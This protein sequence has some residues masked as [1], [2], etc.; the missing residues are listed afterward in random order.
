[1]P[2]VSAGSFEVPSQLRKLIGVI[3]G[4]A[5]RKGEALLCDLLQRST[6]T[7]EEAVE[8]DAWGAGI[9]GH[10]VHFLVPP[11]VFMRID[12]DELEGLANAV[13]E[14]LNKL[15][16]V[17]NEY[18]SEVT[19]EV[20]E[21]PITGPVRPVPTRE[22][23]S[24]LW[25]DTEFLRLFISHKAEVRVLATQIKQACLR[26][27][28]SCFVAHEDIE[29][30]AEWQTEIERAMQSMDALLALLTP[31]FHESNWTDQEVGF[32]LGAQVPVIP[33]K[34]G[35]DPYGFVGRYQAV[36]GQNRSGRELAEEVLAICLDRFDNTRSRM[37]TAL[38]AR[39][40]RAESFAQAK[41]LIR[42][43]EQI[44]TLPT[45]LV[46]RLEAAP[47][48]NSQLENAFEVQR[49]L[50]RILARLRQA[51]AE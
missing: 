18:L 3:A 19:M 16:T 31:D 30:T 42:S 9:S 2:D 50:P 10:A 4:H 1:M 21:A 25:G 45:D 17:R 29:P 20:S 14:R 11:E 6:Y 27:G 26:I 49:R 22:A 43:L 34:L 35:Q 48:N 47:T 37:Q 46:D 32:A 5:C 33:V 13:T 51:I 44:D 7:I 24:D 28:I 40:E 23:H 36:Q 8:H 39:F 41:D 12:I 38:V 15:V